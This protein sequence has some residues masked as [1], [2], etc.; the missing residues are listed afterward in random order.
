[1]VT[2]PQ[3]LSERPVF[4]LVF[5]HG[6]G[7]NSGVFTKLIASLESQLAG[8]SLPIAFTFSC[9]DL[10]GHGHNN[11]QRPHAGASASDWQ[12]SSMAS[13]IADQLKANSILI[14]WSLGGLIAQKLAV[15]QNTKVKALITIA[16]TPKF[17]MGSSSQREWPG[18]KPEVLQTFVEQLSLNHHKTLSR[19]L[20]IQMM[21][22]ANA[23]ALVKEISAAIEQR[24]APDPSALAAGLHILQQA[25][26]C[27]Q[28][29]NISVPTLR[30]YGRLDSLVPH[31]VIHLIQ[32]LQ[33]ESESVIFKHA[34]HAPFLTNPDVFAEH[35]LPFIKQVTSKHPH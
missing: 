14:G 2:S 33:P 29:A 35:L 1:M 20:A 9:I 21:G 10:P 25:D 31:S 23:K 34:S 16:S 30:L 22:V 6:W 28:I 18:I 13:A 3:Q 19:F 24:P 17:Q 8:L 27:E 32:S 4:N 15:D 5:L 12:L 7:M 11:K 26:L